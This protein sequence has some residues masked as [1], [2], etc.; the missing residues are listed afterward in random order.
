MPN[1]LHS[2]DHPHGLAAQVAATA[3]TLQAHLAA[4]ERAHHEVREGIDQLYKMINGWQTTLI[5]GFAGVIIALLA[6]IWTTRIPH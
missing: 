4:C 6:Y 3:A 1:D 2:D 5:T